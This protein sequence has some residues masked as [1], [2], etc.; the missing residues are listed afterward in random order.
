MADPVDRVRMIVMGRD[1]AAGKAVSAKPSKKRL[2]FTVQSATP[3]AVEHYSG[4]AGKR[5]RSETPIVDVRLTGD[6]DIEL[7]GLTPR[8]AKA[9][10]SVLSAPSRFKPSSPQ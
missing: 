4:E 2:K 6:C 5:V 1:M 8:E 3:R 10:R 9:F 7:R